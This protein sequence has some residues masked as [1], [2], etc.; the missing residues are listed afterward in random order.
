ML[1]GDA[2]MFGD[3]LGRFYPRIAN[4]ELITVW[5]QLLL[6]GR[7]RHT[8]FILADFHFYPKTR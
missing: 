7:L 3:N 1:I 4:G 5:E 2:D 6:E 8:Q